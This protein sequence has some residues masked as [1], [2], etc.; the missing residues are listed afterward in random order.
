[1]AVAL[2]DHSGN[3]SGMAGPR[4]GNPGHRWLKDRRLLMYTKRGVI[5]SVRSGFRIAGNVRYDPVVLLKCRD[6]NHAR[7]C[8]C[9][10]ELNNQDPGE[11]FRTLRRLPESPDLR[12]EEGAGTEWHGDYTINEICSY[13]LIGECGNFRSILV[14]LRKLSHILGS[15]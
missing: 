4:S 11:L 15:D 1:M 13:I 8:S 3:C 5:Y 12:R 2:G 9:Q 7:S 6:H 10:N 14:R